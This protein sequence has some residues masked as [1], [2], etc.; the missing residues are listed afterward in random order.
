[1][2]DPL[3]LILLLITTVYF[4]CQLQYVLERTSGNKAMT[5]VAIRH[6]EN[7]MSRYWSS[8]VAI[9]DLQ[10]CFRGI[11]F[12]SLAP[13]PLQNFSWVLDTLPPPLADLIPLH[14]I[15]A[16]GVMFCLAIHQNPILLEFIFLNLGSGKAPFTGDLDVFQNIDACR[17][18][19]FVLR[20]WQS[21]APVVKLRTDRIL[22]SN[23]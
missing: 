11:Q 3:N 4:F 8:E 10:S 12:R 13:C 1:M 23:N 20:S 6:N 19:V 16:L 14:V 17:I 18:P 5:R 22:D 7:R 9:D 15:R 2:K 21:G